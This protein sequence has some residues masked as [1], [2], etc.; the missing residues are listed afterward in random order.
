M[1]TVYMRILNSFVQTKAISRLD[2]LRKAGSDQIFYRLCRNRLPAVNHAMIG[3]ALIITGHVVC[4][5]LHTGAGA[6]RRQYGPCFI[7]DNFFRV[8]LILLKQRRDVAIR[9]DFPCL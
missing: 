8:I 7:S 1:L 6:K 3:Q 5:T 9:S 4:C 2:Q